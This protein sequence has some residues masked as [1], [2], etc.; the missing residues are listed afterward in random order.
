MTACPAP[1]DPA[2]QRRSR[3]GTRRLKRLAAATAFGIMAGSAGGT[4]FAANHLDRAEHLLAAGRVRDARIELRNALRHHQDAGHAAYLLAGVDLE[5]GNPVAAERDARTAMSAGYEPERS[6][7]LLLQS[8]LA[9]GRD[10]ELLHKY[11]VGKQTGTH[12]ALIA[13]ARGQANLALGRP[14]HAAQDFDQA[15]KL[16]PNLAQGWLGKEQLA[17][18][19][20]D[21]AAA[22]AALAKAEATHQDANQVRLHR[23]QLQIAENKPDEAVKTLGALVQSAP[24][25]LPGRLA[26]A[27]ALAATG[28]HE[29]ARHE[30]K[31]ILK[32]EPN[33]A[34]A[35]YLKAA[36]DVQSQDWKAAQTI[37]QKLQPV[38]SKIPGIFL[39]SAQ[40]NAALGLNAVALSNAQHY[41]GA[42][43]QDPHGR[44]VLATI[45]LR[46]GKPKAALHAL[47]PSAWPQ[48][49]PVGATVLGL[50]GEA[51]RQLGDLT[52]AKADFEQAVAKAPHDIRA[53]TSLGQTDL[54]LGHTAEAEK[55]LKKAAAE[56]DAGIIP[57]RLLAD[58][59][60]TA[61]DR[62]TAA[63][64]IAAL[65]KLGDK[66]AAAALR[67]RLE[68]MR[69]DIPAARKA[70]AGL[71]QDKR[72]GREASIGLA[73]LDILEGKPAAA[74]ARLEPV[75]RQDPGNR[76]LVL[77]L[78]SLD[79]SHHD[80]KAATKTLEAAHKAAPKDPVFISDLVDVY[81]EDHDVKAAKTLL[82][83]LSTS[84]V[85]TPAVLAAQ[86]KVAL[87]EHDPKTARGRLTQILNAHPKADPVRLAIARLD[88]AMKD[89]AAA[90]SVL[91]SGLAHAPQD[92]TLMQG[93]VGLS[94][95]QGGMKAAVQEARHL[96]A[97]Q[98]HQPAAASL[99]GDLYMSQKHPNQAAQA[100]AAAA[101]VSPSPVLALDQAKALLTAGKPNAASDV[102][103]KAATAY[104]KQ[105]AF[106][107]LRGQIALDAGKLPQAAAQYRMVLSLAP[108]NVPALNN[109]AWIDQQLGKPDARSLAERAFTQSPGA[110]T[111]DTL[112]WILFKSGHM[113]RAVSLLA[114]AHRR[115]PKDPDIA[116]HYAT[117]LSHNG[118]NTEAA[119]VLKPII[120]GKEHFRDRMAAQ[121]L[122][123]QLSHGS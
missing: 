101:K 109:L 77:A 112:G 56:P 117:A 8:F 111:A 115:A 96:A 94:L 120:A 122:Y 66:G 118:K 51:E 123:Q 21:L 18:S 48:G 50:R 19:R 68:L 107:M 45:A 49:A 34:T 93:L 39:L 82:N 44:L 95:H 76:R 110:Q 106:P 80:L 78:V 70:L 38:A 61:G 28:K 81:L 119:A 102:L 67:A 33:S 59:A 41:V 58:A 113:G 26:Y 63:H 114:S 32:I 57:N 1:R 24:S 79:L 10:V 42:R 29:T 62:A 104:P 37:L 90:R 60:L 100:Y 6:F 99:L 86:A 9:Q 25:F 92:I 108:N 40:T 47:A 17:L 69:G 85:T 72:T 35:M 64:A 73:H 7:G 12:A 97:D 54:A 31:K 16:D 83:N 22:K 74:R 87:A 98:A 75:V 88:V 89:N 13:A 55:I 65:D 20:G 4:A 103:S 121:N 5:L 27:D 11:K 105:P 43:P 116:F 91:E 15:V 84:L 23:G 46:G 36:L 3:G 71:Q 2:S 53:L 14:D 52:A 30:L